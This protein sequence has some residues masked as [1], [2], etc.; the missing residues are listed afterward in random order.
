MVELTIQDFRDVLWVNN[1]AAEFST[2][3]QL[4]TE[5]LHLLRKTLKA[6]KGNFFLL[7]GTNPQADFYRVISLGVEER[8]VRL[9]QRYY[10]QL[11][12][13]AMTVGP[14]DPTV[15]TTD[16]VVIFKNFVRTEYYNDFL[17]PQ[18]IHHQMTFYLKNKHR[19][20]GVVTLFRSRKA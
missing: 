3:N 19:L 10:Y 14:S 16:D 6:E 20:L 5:V 2:V 8:A 18:S 13:F 17:K 1:C 9:Y 12:P 11:D 7:P 15:V 4:R